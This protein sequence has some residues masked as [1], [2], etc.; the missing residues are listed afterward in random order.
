MKAIILA[1]GKGSRLGHLTKNRPKC[2][3]EFGG[4]KIIEYQLDLFAKVGIQDVII[5]RGQF[6]DQIKYSRVKYYDDFDQNNMVHSLFKAEKEL[7]GDVIIS[8]GDIIFEEHVL[9][10]LIACKENISVI[11]DENWLNYYS[12]RYTKPY[13]EAESLILDDNKNILEIGSSLPGK[14]SIQGQYIGLLK[15]NN[16][17]NRIFRDVYF[18]SKIRYKGK[19]WIRG[20]TFEKIYLT[21]FLQILIDKKYTVSSV[22]VRN[23]WLEFDTIEDFRKYNLWIKN[24]SINVF[25]PSLAKR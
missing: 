10:S 22:L 23:G 11:I 13:I 15:L 24:G 7:F 6:G 2:L 17:G 20:R 1:A 9:M 4:K 12:A 25:L 16:L 5:V 21:D 3:L 14:K 19:S 8:Y 18:N